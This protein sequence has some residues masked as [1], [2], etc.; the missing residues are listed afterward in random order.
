MK[1]SL[2]LA[3]SLL[4]VAV[5]SIVTAQDGSTYYVNVRSAKVRA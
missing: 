2:L 3:L 1:R 5:F 4:L